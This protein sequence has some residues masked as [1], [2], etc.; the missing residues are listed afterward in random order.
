VKSN[1]ATATE[2]PNRNKQQLNLELN[3]PNVLILG[4]SGYLGTA[5]AQALLRS[6]GYAVWGTARSA[7]KAAQL[8]AIEVSPVE[9]VDLANPQTLTQ[10][11]DAYHIDAVVDASSAYEQA[12]GVLEAVVTAAKARAAALANDKAIGPKLAFVYT[13]GSWVHGSPSR[14]VSDLV[15]LHHRTT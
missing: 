11:I 14:R 4:G 13:S 9:S 6:G 7:G 2:P 10:A 5:I 15:R 1:S 8:R 12:A 3:M